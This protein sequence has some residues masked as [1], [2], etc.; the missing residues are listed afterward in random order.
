MSF[1]FLTVRWALLTKIHK[2]GNSSNI[3]RENRCDDLKNDHTSIV[4]KFPRSFHLMNQHV[5]IK[6]KVP[7]RHSEWEGNCHI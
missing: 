6:S 5:F 3:G 1:F 7:V 2:E 4:M